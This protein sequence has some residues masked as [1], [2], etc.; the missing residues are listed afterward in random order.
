MYASSFLKRKSSGNMFAPGLGI[1]FKVKTCVHWVRL[2][3][4]MAFVNEVP[5]NR[6]YK[7]TE[8]NK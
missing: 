1:F 8:T 3:F 6:S 4:S 5:Q 2:H 7:Q